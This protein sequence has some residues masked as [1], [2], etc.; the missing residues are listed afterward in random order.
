MQYPKPVIS[1]TLLFTGLGWELVPLL[2]RASYVDWDAFRFVRM[3]N[4][5]RGVDTANPV[6]TEWL[7]LRHNYRTVE[8]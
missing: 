1:A 4:V 7:Q 2:D 3:W 8:A 5:A 6:F